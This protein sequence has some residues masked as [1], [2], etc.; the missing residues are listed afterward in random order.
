M[1]LPGCIVIFLSFLD[2][3]S[4]L[5]L[6]SPTCSYRHDHRP[7]SCSLHALAHSD[8]LTPSHCL[9]LPAT[10]S[11]RRGWLTT[12]GAMLVLQSNSAYAAD[13]LSD[14][15]VLVVEDGPI[16]IELMDLSRCDCRYN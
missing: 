7:D 13:V 14:E 15:Y 1:R 5:L 8:G 10:I 12:A 9:Q 3:A 11:S 2:S 16:G 4:T 6:P